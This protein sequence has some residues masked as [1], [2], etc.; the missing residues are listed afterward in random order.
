MH[1][2]ITEED[3]T[4]EAP[5]IAATEQA[6]WEALER[7]DAARARVQLSL[8]MNT[9]LQYFDQYRQ[10]FT[11]FFTNLI[12]QRDRLQFS[13]NEYYQWGKRLESLKE[14]KFAIICFDFAAFQEENAHIQKNSL[15]EASR[16]RIKTS[17]QLGKVQRDMEFLLSIDPDGIAGNQ[18]R[19]VLGE[20]GGMS[21]LPMRR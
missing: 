17:Y 1:E 7:G 13:Q 12:K 16:L 2:S 21:S 6:G 8:A 18:A 3:E 5:S 4:P 19:E 10:G 9:S 20:L 14:Y 11:V 15:L